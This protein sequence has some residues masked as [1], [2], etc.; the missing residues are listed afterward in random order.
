[1]NA[2]EYV[3]AVALEVQEAVRGGTLFLD[4]DADWVWENAVKDLGQAA[5]ADALATSIGSPWLSIEQAA[6]YAHIDA[7]CLKESIR[8]G[9]VPAYRF[10]PKS[11][12]LVNARAIDNWIEQEWV[13]A[14]E[15]TIGDVP[16]KK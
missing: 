2:E 10:T 13:T 6:A 11:E 9:E 4:A 8:M 12:P 1:M 7:L 15:A 14:R 3:A 5:A 16:T